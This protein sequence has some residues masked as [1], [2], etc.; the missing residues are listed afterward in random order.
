MVRLDP[1]FVLL[2]LPP[3]SKLFCFH[4]LRI[5]SFSF[6]FL[7]N[8]IKFVALATVYHLITPRPLY[9]PHIPPKLQTKLLSPKGL[10]STWTSTC[11][12]PGHVQPRVAGKCSPIEST[13]LEVC[14]YSSMWVLSMNFVDDAT[15]LS[16]G[17]AHLT[18]VCFISVDISQRKHLTWHC[19]T[20]CRKLLISVHHRGLG[21][22]SGLGILTH[23]PAQGQ[24]CWQL[25]GERM[26]LST[27]HSSSE[28][29]SSSP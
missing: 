10:T 19:Y 26:C 16:E 14:D 20:V 21:G 5:L 12:L 25:M 13:S 2:S 23:G 6:S 27:L 29:K 1:E 9:G 7:G 4:H 22:V 17:R 24:H 11:C 15:V 8:M 3:L 18:R 28:A